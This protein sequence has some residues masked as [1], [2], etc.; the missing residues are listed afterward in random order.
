MM[1]DSYLIQYIYSILVSY[2]Y[3]LLVVW[4][5]KKT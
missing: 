2:Q 3:G 1:S 4:L 5:I